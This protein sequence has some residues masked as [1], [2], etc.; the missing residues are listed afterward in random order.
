M[1]EKGS[2]D[3]LRGLLWYEFYWISIEYCHRQLEKIIKETF[4]CYENV[5]SCSL[6]LGFTI[7]TNKIYQLRVG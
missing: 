4:L 5:Q 3:L 7:K 6:G 1:S 2:F